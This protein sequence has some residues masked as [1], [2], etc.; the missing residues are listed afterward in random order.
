MKHNVN[1]LL[2]KLDRDKVISLDLFLLLND[3]VHLKNG[4]SLYLNENGSIEIVSQDQNFIKRIFVDTL[5][6]DRD[7]DLIVND[8][9]VATLDELLDRK[10]LDLTDLHLKLT[11]K[12]KDSEDHE[13]TDVIG[14]ASS[15]EN[16]F[17]L[18]DDSDLQISSNDSI[19]EVILETKTVEDVMD[20][21][22]EIA[23]LNKMSRVDLVGDGSDA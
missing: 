1:K 2:L 23:D 4:R 21:L 19:N 5:T 14:F 7:L 8:E 6:F 15:V 17:Y 12:I 20:W 9:K 13:W 16:A 11:I 22:K 18:L 3:R 10:I